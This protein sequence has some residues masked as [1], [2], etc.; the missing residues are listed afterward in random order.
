MASFTLSPVKRSTYFFEP[1]FGEYPDIL[2]TPKDF[3]SKTIQSCEAYLRELCAGTFVNGHKW[4]PSFERRVLPK[5]PLEKLEPCTRDE[6]LARLRL[7]LSEVRAQAEKGSWYPPVK[8]GKRIKVSLQEF[9][10]VPK[11][12]G[13][14]SPFLEYYTKAL[15][16]PDISI[17]EIKAELG[18]VVTDIVEKV[19]GRRGRIADERFWKGAMLLLDW[20]SS[21]PDEAVYKSQQ[22]QLLLGKASSLF[23]AVA[24]Y[25]QKGGLITDVFM[26]PTSYTWGKFKYWLATEKRV[27]LEP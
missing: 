4:M 5:V 8:N 15:R 18:P 1:V 16:S 21:L 13:T 12:A 9:L 11:P 23:R 3:A 24:E 27:I 10:L 19:A 2:R 17:A 20:W 25:Q 6:M 14:M 7:A 26:G 22:S